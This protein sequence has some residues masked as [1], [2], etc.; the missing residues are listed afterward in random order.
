MSC[1]GSSLSGANF[2]FSE[3]MSPSSNLSNKLLHKPLPSF[4]DTCFSTAKIGSLGT[5]GYDFNPVP[6]WPYFFWLGGDFRWLDLLIFEFLNKLR[7]RI[8]IP[9]A[10]INPTPTSLLDGAKSW[11]SSSSSSGEA[12]SPRLTKLCF[13]SYALISSD[14][15][16]SS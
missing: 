3:V 9:S 1:L 4:Y 2:C 11:F 16:F 15:F 14:V 8:L 7:P 12:I 10:E 13:L 6:F 5:I